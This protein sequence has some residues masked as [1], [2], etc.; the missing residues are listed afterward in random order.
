MEKIKSLPKEIENAR[1]GRKFIKMYHYGRWY[2]FHVISNKG[3]DW[4]DV[5]KAKHMR[6]VKTK[7]L[8]DVYPKDATFDKEKD[9]WQLDSYE[10]CLD[11][12]REID[13]KEKL[14]HQRNPLLKDMKE[15]WLD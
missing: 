8:H 12:I 9:A 2:I 1:R 3:V 14:E 15:L 13:K 6:N 5:F 10:E 7:K 4:Y 11:K